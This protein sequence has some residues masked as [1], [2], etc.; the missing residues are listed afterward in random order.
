[1]T[2]SLARGLWVPALTPFTAD[3]QPDRA[4]FIAHCRWLLD[5]GADGL[6][7]FGTTSEAN[8]LSTGERISLLDALIDAGIP[9]NRLL[10]G[11]GMCA[12]T[13]S[14]TLTAHAT[15]NGCKGVLMLPPFYYKT[16]SDDG[17]YAS[18]SQVIER[19][20][21]PKL[22]VYLYHIPPV[23]QVPIS[24]GLM[25]RLRRDY[26]ATVVGIKDSSGDAAHTSELVRRF[27]DMAVFPGAESYLLSALREGA[28]GCISASANVNAAGIA[29]VIANRD[30]PDAERRQEQISQVR[31]TLQAYPII[32][33]MKGLLASALADPRWRNI[34]PPLEVL[35]EARMR[36]LQGELD[37]IGF[38]V[39]AKP[40]SAAA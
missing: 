39:A 18:F 1:V 36:K 5:Q 38:R 30:A 24:F 34:R 13:D 40:A 14:A 22:K 25:E 10:P 2:D 33:A 4:R 7:V 8:S 16:V 11:T 15:L 3:F 17:L 26:P 19:V 23:A 29:G 31:R 6:A 35:D 12:L 27:P 21:N 37:A 9:A 32:A 28:V 20:G